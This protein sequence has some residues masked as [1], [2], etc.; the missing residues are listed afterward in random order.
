MGGGE[1]G[2][3]KGLTKGTG[4]E[5]VGRGGGEL[6]GDGKRGVARYVKNSNVSRARRT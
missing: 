4:V 1:T 2:R 6:E 3:A 5:R